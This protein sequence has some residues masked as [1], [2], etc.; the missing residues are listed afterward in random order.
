[1]DDV[2]ST[3]ARDMIE[4]KMLAHPDEGVR[5]ITAAF[6]VPDEAVE[7]IASKLRREAE[8]LAQMPDS[9]IDTS[10]IPETTNWAGAV[11]GLFRR[12][13]NP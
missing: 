13:R 5:A 12:D 10:D 7:Q 8:G 9:E 6:G 1:M 3:R 11:R 2:F 4:A